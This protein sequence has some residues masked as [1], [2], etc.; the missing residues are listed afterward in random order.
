MLGEQQQNSLVTIQNTSQSRKKT[1]KEEWSEAMK[2][3]ITQITRRF[4]ELEF[5][6][7][8]VK[9][10]DKCS[11]AEIKNLHKALCKINSTYD[12]G[13]C[14]KAKKIDAQVEGTY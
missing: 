8:A 9:A 4:Q 6:G 5:D 11:D 3:H 14:S 1:L 10:H 13:I 12:P 2:L 7:R